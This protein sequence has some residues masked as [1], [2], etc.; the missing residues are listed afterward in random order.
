MTF[1]QIIESVLIGVGLAMD[2][3]AVSVTTGFSLE[4]LTKKAALRLAFFFGLFQGLMPL[5]GWLLGTVF[6]GA[7]STYDHWIAF[8]I[9]FVIGGKMLVNAIKEKPGERSFNINKW[10]V[11]I[12][13]SIATSIDAMIVGLSFPSMYNETSTIIFTLINITVVTFILSLIGLFFGKKFSL[14]IGNKAE[15]LGG[16]ILIL[17]GTKTLLEHLGIITY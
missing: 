17:I 11:I 2:C 1:I 5:L 15:A 6:H 10:A 12:S 13:L 16:I 4:C 7:I 14:Y 3:F 8:A 9:L